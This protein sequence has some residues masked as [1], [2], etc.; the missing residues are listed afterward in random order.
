MTAGKPAAPGQPVSDAL[1]LARQIEHLQRMQTHLEHSIARATPIIAAQNFA[2]PSV[3]EHEI[4]AAFRARFSEFQEHLGKA[5][6]LLTIVEEASALRFGAVLAY[7]EKIGVLTDAARFNAMREACNKINH[8]YEDDI[9]ELQELFSSLL[10]YA[11]E[12]LQ[13]FARLRRF[14][15][16]GEAA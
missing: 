16:L 4:L 2:A 11:P 9:A 1:L 15:M 12:M 7:M 13:C 5:M 14:V 3:D 8:Q 6:R 10:I